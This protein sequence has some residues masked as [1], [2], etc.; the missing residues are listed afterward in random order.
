MQSE[1]HI[2]KQ[3][4]YKNAGVFVCLYSQCSDGKADK[5]VRKTTSKRYKQTPG[6]G[7]TGGRRCQTKVR[8]RP[9]ALQRHPEG[10]VR[11]GETGSVLPATRRHSAPRLHHCHFFWEFQLSTCPAKLQENTDMSAVDL[12]AYTTK[13]TSYLKAQWKVWKDRLKENNRGSLI[14]MNRHSQK[15]FFKHYCLYFSFTL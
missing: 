8:S 9:A 6:C 12:P 11:E 7:W 14:L 10:G 15:P 3:E 5:E 2:E 13:I 4:C 1:F